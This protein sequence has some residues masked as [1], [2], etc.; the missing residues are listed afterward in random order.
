MST[1]NSQN[2]LNQSSTPRQCPH[3]GYGIAGAA[4]IKSYCSNCKKGLNWPVSAI[5]SSASTGA[6]SPAFSTPPS[7]SKTTSSTTTPVPTQPVPTRPATPPP[8]N[9][10]QHFTPRR[11]KSLLPTTFWGW[12]SLVVIAYLVLHLLAPLL[13]MLALLGHGIFFAVIIAA[14]AFKLWLLFTSLKG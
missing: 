12:A 1:G 8:T 3:C 5:G 14:I 13:G 6:S 11:S 7:N 4:Q 2:T 10:P 9:S